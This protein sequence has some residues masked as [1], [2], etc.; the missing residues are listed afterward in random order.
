MVYTVYTFVL[1]TTSPS[2]KPKAQAVHGRIVHAALEVFARLGVEATRVEDLLLSS[3]VSR[4]TF[5]KYFHSKEDVLAAVYEQ[6]TG[7]L[8]SAVGAC[9]AG[10]PLAAIRRTLDAYLDLHVQNPRIVRVLQEHAV[11]AD[12]PLAPIRQRFRV[13]LVTRLGQAFQRAT[14]RA[15]EPLMFVAL[16]SALEGVSLEILAGKPNR[17]EVARAGAALHALLDALLTAASVDGRS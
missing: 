7:E 9:E 1:P 13:E 8:L 5:Y 11:R 4:R 2:L 16:I 15:A 6:I 10:D 14:G 12:S 17:A 3:G